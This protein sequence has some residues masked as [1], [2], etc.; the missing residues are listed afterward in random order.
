MA[1]VINRTTFQYLRSVNTPDYPVADW[2]INPTAAEIRSAATARDAARPPPVKSE[3]Q[4]FI[5]LEV[6]VAALERV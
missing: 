5:D 3:E 6:R 4:E 1:D 2:I